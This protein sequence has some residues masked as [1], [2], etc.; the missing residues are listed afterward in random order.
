VWKDGN[1]R[2]AKGGNGGVKIIR[3]WRGAI[4]RR[5]C[6]LRGV[7]KT[8]DRKKMGPTCLE[9]YFLRRPGIAISYHA[10][11]ASD[12]MV[13]LSHNARASPPTAWYRYLIPRGPDLASGHMI[14]RQ[15]KRERGKEGLPSTRRGKHE[16][17]THGLGDCSEAELIPS[18]KRKYGNRLRERICT[19]ASDV[20][21]YRPT[22]RGGM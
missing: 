11:L 15:K 16:V 5:L 13:S 8:E 1:G 2:Q 12:G 20:R 4:R 18:Y 21:V 3:N 22:G 17:G 7:L 14:K 9:G 19:I 6:P 10:D